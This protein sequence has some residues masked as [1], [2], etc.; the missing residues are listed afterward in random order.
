MI[1]TYAT[2]LHAIYVAM[3]QCLPN[4]VPISPLE[5]PFDSWQ[6]KSVMPPYEMAESSCSCYMCFVE[7][8][9]RRP[10]ITYN[11]TC[12]LDS[13]RAFLFKLRV[14]SAVN[15]KDVGRR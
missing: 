5:S 11:Y 8:I 2:R 9:T 12:T 10:V 13:E 14:Q 1:L 6:F 4:K 3:M 15:S 7:Q